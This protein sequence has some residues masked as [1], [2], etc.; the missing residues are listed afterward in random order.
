MESNYKNNINKIYNVGIYLRLS[1]EDEEHTTVSQSILNQ[2]DFLTTY[3]IENGFNIIDYYIDDGY[4]GTN[5]DRPDFKR[6]I[7]DIEKGRINTVITKDLSRLGRDYIM[8]GHYIEKYF[9]EKNIRYI[10]VND[11]IDTYIEDNND[12][13][14]FK[15]VIK[16][17]RC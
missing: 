9:P 8:T 11:N 4:S 1:K 12:M 14:P 10:A 7:E 16:D 6:L 2:K 17:T 13:T 5:F 15:S 3:A